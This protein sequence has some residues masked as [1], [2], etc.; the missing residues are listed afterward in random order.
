M[1]PMWI[2]VTYVTTLKP[3]TGPG[4]RECMVGGTISPKKSRCWC[5]WFPRY[6]G[7]NKISLNKEDLWLAPS[8]GAWD[9]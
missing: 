8:D 5:H 6:N 1:E 7:A 4:P 2:S 9:P 3:G